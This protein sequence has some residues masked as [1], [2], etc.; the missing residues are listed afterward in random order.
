MCKIY[1]NKWNETDFIKFFFCILKSKCFEWF[2]IYNL[3]CSKSEQ[4]FVFWLTDYVA[5]VHRPICN[6]VWRYAFRWWDKPLGRPQF[7]AKQTQLSFYLRRTN[8]HFFLLGY[9]LSNIHL[10][11][12]CTFFHRSLF[13]LSSSMVWVLDVSFLY[14]FLQLS[15]F[16]F[17]ANYNSMT[18]GPI[19]FPLLYSNFSW[20]PLLNYLTPWGSTP[21]NLPLGPFATLG[22]LICFLRLLSK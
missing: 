21:S 7:W 5:N 8:H 1:L 4:F 6:N 2:C 18:R 16:N 11:V 20:T 10:D 14:F 22:K 9:L 3:G 12:L 15:H 17:W 19:H 13:C